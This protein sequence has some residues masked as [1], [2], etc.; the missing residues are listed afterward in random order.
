MTQPT[1]LQVIDFKPPML[2]PTLIEAAKAEGINVAELKPERI[3]F[4]TGGILSFVFPNKADG[5]Q[6]LRQYFDAVILFNHDCN[7]YWPDKKTKNTPP[8]CSSYDGIA[9]SYVDDN[10]QRWLRECASCPHNQFGTGVD[11][12]GERTRGKACKNMHR[13]YPLCSDEMIRPK[14][15]NLP[16]T[17]VDAFAPDWKYKNIVVEGQLQ[18]D[19]RTSYNTIIRTSLI[20]KPVSGNDVA[21]AS[22]KVIGRVDPKIEGYL[23]EMQQEIRLKYKEVAIIGDDYNVESSGGGAG[24]GDVSG[25]NL[26]DIDFFKDQ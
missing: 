12:S 2:D 24:T 6:D 1:A 18:K 25:V 8:F 14:L 10:G 20:S 21:I 13:I 3:L 9:G 26:N 22:F 5:S 17:S 23:K 15:C 4:P 19:G 7:A 16:P 11:Q